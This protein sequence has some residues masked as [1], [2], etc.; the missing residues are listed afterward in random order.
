[1]SNLS[2]DGIIILSDDRYQLLI[3]AIATSIASG[4]GPREQGSA[5]VRAFELL[6]RVGI[7]PECVLAV[8]LPD[9]LDDAFHSGELGS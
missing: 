4:S 5:S 1:M 8:V 6:W 2:G 3:R 7:F 9:D